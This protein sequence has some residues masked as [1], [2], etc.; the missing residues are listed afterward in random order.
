MLLLGNIK[1]YNGR[2]S[3]VVQQLRLHTRDAGGLD[4]IPGQRTRSHMLQLRLGAV[5]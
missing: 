2:T 4:S 3:P 1:L 5:K